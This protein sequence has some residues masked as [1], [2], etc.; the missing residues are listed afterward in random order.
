MHT[1]FKKL[2]GTLVLYKFMDTIQYNKQHADLQKGRYCS[3]FKVHAKGTSRCRKEIYA[4]EEATK[5]EV[6]QQ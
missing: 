2:E 3:I 5:P 6:G 4:G 1:D